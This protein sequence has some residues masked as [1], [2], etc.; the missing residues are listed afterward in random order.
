MDSALAWVGQIAEWIGRFFPRWVILD[1]TEG[2]VKYVG[3][4]LPRGLRL[5]FRGFDGDMRVQILGPGLHWYWPATTKL[6]EHPTARQ[7]DNL[8]TQ[9]IVTSDDKCVAVS[10]ML[11]YEVRDLGAFVTQTFSPMHLVQDISLTAIHDVCSN[12]TWEELKTKQQKGTLDTALKNAA[13]KQLEPY[14]IK[15]IKC[16]LTDLA[17]TRVLRLIQTTSQD[18]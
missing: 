1:V 4:F 8:P 18:T 3:Y 13:H 9:T 7:A 11:V 12:F 5:R 15:V 10:G 16:M 17:I 2:G 6:Q 14:G